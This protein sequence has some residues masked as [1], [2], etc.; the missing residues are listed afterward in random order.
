MHSELG[1]IGGGHHDPGPGYPIDKVITYALALSPADHK[2]A[3]W[4]RHLQDN[5][6]RLKS[7]LALR[8]R[9]RQNKLEQSVRYAAT[10]KQ[11]S[12][13]RSTIDRLKR[14]TGKR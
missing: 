3:V 11:L 6:A 10:G 13:L 8:A 14:L 7:L 5:R 12:L 4:K 9:L 1:A 2:Q